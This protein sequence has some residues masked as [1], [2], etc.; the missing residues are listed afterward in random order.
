[1]GALCTVKVSMLKPTQNAL[2]FD[3]VND[4]ITRHGRKSEADLK[5]YLLVRQVPIAIVLL[6]RTISGFSKA[7]QP[8]RLLNR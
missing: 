3:E 5:E 8:K 7:D 1:M 2:G 4:K 6:E